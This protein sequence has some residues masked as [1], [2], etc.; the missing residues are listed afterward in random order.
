MA[1]DYTPIYCEGE[2]FTR[3]TSAAV[4]AG[5][6]LVVSG[7]DTVAPSSGASVAYLGVAAFDA[8]SG[9]EVTVL[10]GGVHE[11]AASGAIAAGELVTTAASGAVATQATPSAANAVQVIGVAL[12][13]AAS[14]KV[15][16]KL[17]R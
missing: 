11:L 17:F 7:D 16:V 6:A 4:T 12:K 13:A 5:Q 8:A 15:T 14:N 3:V 9:A 2:A 10:S 1:T